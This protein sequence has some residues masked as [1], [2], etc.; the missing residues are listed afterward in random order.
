MAETRE[1]GVLM[2]RTPWKRKWLTQ[3]VNVEEGGG[4]EAH[5]AMEVSTIATATATATI[6]WEKQLRSA[7][8]E[9]EQTKEIIDLFAAKAAN[10]IV[11]YGKPLI[12]HTRIWDLTAQGND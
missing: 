4:N 7:L 10:Y 3:V 5:W 8:E 2:Y 12:F 11:Y 1:A 6:R 9:I